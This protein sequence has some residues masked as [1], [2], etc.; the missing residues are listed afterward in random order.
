[1]LRT[2]RLGGPSFD[3]LNPD[4]LRS[5]RI[6]TLMVHVVAGRKMNREQF[7]EKLATLD[8]DRLNKALW[9]L[10]WR[11]T[12]QMRERIEAELDP[13]ERD[14]RR[15]IAVEVVAADTVLDE[16]RE[17]AALARS[18]AY[19][20]GD[21]RVTPKERTRWRFTFKQ[22][23]SDSVA[24]LRTDD[25][26]T[27]A[28]AVAELIDLAC[29]MRGYEYFRSEDPIEAARFVVSDA[30]AM[31]WATIRDRH[32]FAFFAEHAAPQ[33]IAWESEFGWTR[34]GFGRVADQEI[35]LGAVIA[36]MLPATDMWITFTDHYLAALD[37]LVDTAS[38]TATTRRRGYRAA[39]SRRDRAEN[40]AD[41]NLALLDRLFGS[42]AEDRLDRLATHPAFDGPEKTFLEAH[43]AR[44]RGDVDTARALIQK[45]LAQLPGHQG[46]LAF[47]TEIGA[48]T[49]DRSRGR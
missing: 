8:E 9:T 35:P 4:L 15:K 36:K 38:S 25:V 26:D 40:L 17:F 16:I 42:E 34:S 30:V 19:L 13:D 33:L 29:E 37:R 10:Y 31:M 44:Q 45:C 32:G 1:M 20:G 12:A 43:L 49:P 3:R 27:A 6:R 24:S 22:L 48:Q 46:F 14:R 39:R 2:R 21:R 5:A 11:G 41:W 7:F 23:A 28:A 47:A 18:G